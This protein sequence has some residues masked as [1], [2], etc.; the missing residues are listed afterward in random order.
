MSLDPASRSPRT[1]ELF[2][3]TRRVMN[4]AKVDSEKRIK[5]CQQS[6][7]YLLSFA[8]H[9]V[10]VHEIGSNLPEECLLAIGVDL[11]LLFD[12]FHLFL[13]KPSLV[14]NRD[15]TQPYTNYATVL[16]LLQWQALESD[17]RCKRWIL[18]CP[19]HLGMLPY[20]E[21]AMPDAKIIWI[22]RSLDQVIPSFARLIRVGMDMT[23]GQV[24][25]LRQLGQ[26][27][28]QFAEE[29]INRGQQY[30]SKNN[31]G[32]Q[33]MVASNVQIYNLSYARLV[34][35]PLNTI[36][37]LY[38]ELDLPFSNEYQKHLKC[39]VA[40]QTT[41]DSEDIE[42]TPYPEGYSMQEYGI[43]NEKLE[44]TFKNYTTK[45]KAFL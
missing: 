1:W 21:Q 15:C 9:L 44:I 29:W 45:Y 16:Q 19:I 3:P 4:D 6:L 7:D 20:L 40:S 2:D 5:Y 39:F 14:Y 37:Y 28:V 42:C 12:T 13:K 33:K 10:K 11:P 23:V 31:E 36:K 27:C 38:K 8:P 34:K 35:D 30:V 24:I 17:S 41:L 18:K 43:T 25:D 32:K 22:H 26:N